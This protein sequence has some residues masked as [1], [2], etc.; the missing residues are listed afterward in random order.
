MNEKIVDKIG[1][2]ASLMAVL[3][4]LSYI[5]QLR[6]NLSGQPGSVFLPIV[7]TVNCTTW[8][9]YGAFKTK[10]DWPIIIAN[11][12]GVVLGIATAVTAVI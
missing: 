11:I 6:L 8:M 12:P 2:T 5:D 10:C 4:Y 7:T 3:M 1:W 9:I